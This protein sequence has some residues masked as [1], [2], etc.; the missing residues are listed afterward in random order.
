MTAIKE[1]LTLVFIMIAIGCVLILAS[2][3]AGASNLVRESGWQIHLHYATPV[4]VA[5]RTIGTTFATKELCE[6]VRTTIMLEFIN[7]RVV[8]R[9]VDELW[10]R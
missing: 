6:D 3:A 5:W 10:S 7:D 1:G 9:W 4:D 2:A 8:C